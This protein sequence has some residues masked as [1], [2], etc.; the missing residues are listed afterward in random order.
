M[1]KIQ[2]DPDSI[3]D[4]DLEWL[5]HEILLTELKQFFLAM[6]VSVIHTSSR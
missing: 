3:S 6:P 5:N 1:Y 4:H 2:V